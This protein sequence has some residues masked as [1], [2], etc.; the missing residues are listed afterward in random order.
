[1][2][3]HGRLKADIKI[4]PIGI[5]RT[6]TFN[7]K[8]LAKIAQLVSYKEEPPDLMTYKHLPKP[9]K[10]I[11][12]ALHTYT[13]TRMAITYLPE[14]SQ[15]THDKIKDTKICHHNIAMKTYRLKTISTLAAG[16]GGRGRGESE[17]GLH[18]A[19]SF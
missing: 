18:R 17:Y 1:M 3:T 15:E 14:F 6:C 13:R 2:Q 7:V 16:S 19:A 11:D 12:M 10:H 8:T 4:I 9:A 5:S